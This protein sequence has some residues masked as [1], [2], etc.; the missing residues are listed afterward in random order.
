MGQC[1]LSFNGRVTL[2]RESFYSKSVEPATTTCS[3]SLKD[4]TGFRAR[5]SSAQ[6]RNENFLQCIAAWLRIAGRLADQITHADSNLILKAAM[7]YYIYLSG[8]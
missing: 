5:P 1:A 4:I 3:L 2:V 7:A 6:N 8:Y